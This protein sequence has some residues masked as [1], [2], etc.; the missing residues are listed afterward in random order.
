MLGFIAF[1]KNKKTPGKTQKARIENV[2]SIVVP[3]DPPPILT[4]PAVQGGPGV[5]VK[6]NL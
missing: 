4:Q 3:P 5:R 2:N 6:E 1:V